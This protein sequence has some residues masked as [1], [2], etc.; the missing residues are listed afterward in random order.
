MH[1]EVRSRAPCR[2]R[3]PKS[4]VGIRRDCVRISEFQ[5]PT[6][7][8]AS[9][10][11]TRYEMATDIT[12]GGAEGPGFH[13]SAAVRCLPRTGDRSAQLLRPLLGR[14]RLSVRSGLHGLR[15]SV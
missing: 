7:P 6:S 12:K 5:F 4:E 13:F 3:N 15:I 8:S 11:R 10:R 14:Y 2:N 9:D 1:G